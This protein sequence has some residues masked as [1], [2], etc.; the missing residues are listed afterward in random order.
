MNGYHR[1]NQKKSLE[2]LLFPFFTVRSQ[3]EERKQM[4]KSIAAIILAMLAI[5]SFAPNLA[6][7]DTEIQK[8]AIHLRGIIMQ[9]GE[10]P[11]FGWVEAHAVKLN[12]N[13]TYHEWALVHAMWSLD[14]PKLNCTKPPTENVT[15]SFYVAHIVPHTEMIRFNY[16]GYIFY[17]SGLWNV[18]KITTSIYVDGSGEIINVTKVFEPILT[19]ATGE[20][21]MLP[22]PPMM[23]APFEL[24]IDGIPMLKGIVIFWR[25]AYVEIKI[26]DITGDNGEP[27][28]KVDIVD[29][30]R[31]A[32]AYKAVPGTPKYS[33]EVDF[34]FNYEIGTGDLTTVGANIEP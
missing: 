23:P 5:F 27:D 14:K 13:G 11:A 26:C 19:N 33:L 6:T 7:A 9:W 22:H 3:R 29:L 32:K 21:R 10:N 25:I 17:I 31:V 30:V 34:D 28:G 15:F 16:S 18:A 12:L 20:F 8:L 24:A 4:R 1:Y 2:R